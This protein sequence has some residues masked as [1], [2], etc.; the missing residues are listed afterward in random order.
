MKL[1]FGDITKENIEQQI[2]NINRNAFPVLYNDAFYDEVVGAANGGANIYASWKDIP[3]GA[4][5]SRIEELADGRRQLYL[6]TI[7]VLAPYRGRGIGTRLIER[8]LEYCTQ[9][10]ISEVSLHVQVSNYDA[11]RFYTSKFN[12]TKGA[13]VENYYRRIDPPNCYHLYKKLD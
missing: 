3:V 1:D 2:K 9:S 5:C 4:V 7:A 6:M 13:M 8:V 11:M 10:G 12:F